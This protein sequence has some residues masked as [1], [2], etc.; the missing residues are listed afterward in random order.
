MNS[1]A[2]RPTPRANTGS[3]LRNFISDSGMAFIRLER[4]FDP[5]FRPAFDAFLRDPLA[6]L[7]TSLIN[8][9]RPNEGLLIAEERLMPDEDSFT[10]SI[11]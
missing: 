8:S 1:N 7:T 10:D 2:S 11:V 4:R 6:R 3:V 5:L 9:Q